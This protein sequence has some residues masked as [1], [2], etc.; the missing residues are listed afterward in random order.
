MQHGR[1]SGQVYAL[2]LAVLSF[3]VTAAFLTGIPPKNDFDLLAAGIAFSGSVGMFLGGWAAYAL[4]QGEG[5]TVERVVLMSPIVIGVA[6]FVASL[7]FAAYFIV[8]IFF[9][10]WYGV[11][12]MGAAILALTVVWSFL[13]LRFETLGVAADKR[14]RRSL[15]VTDRAQFG[16]ALFCGLPGIAAIAIAL[17]KLPSVLP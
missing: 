15:L 12:T 11:T 4:T 17:W 7:P 16:T 2:G 5:P 3:P 14:P 13:Y 6:F 10:W 9:A 8:G 1:D